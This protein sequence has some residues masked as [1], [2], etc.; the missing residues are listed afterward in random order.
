MI[1]HQEVMGI[2]KTILLPA[3]K[4]YALEAGASGN[5]RVQEVVR[6]YPDRYLCFANEVPSEPDAREVIEKYLKM[7][8]RGIGEQKFFIDCT[9]KEMS[10]ISDIA[11][12]HGVPILLHFQHERFNVNYDQFYRTLAR[13]PKV[14]YIGHAQT[15]WANIDLKHEQPILYPKWKVTAGGWTDRYLRDYPNFFADLSA[16]SGLNALQRDE[17]HARQFIVRHQDK[18]LYGSDCNDHIG[19]G[20]KCSGSQQIAMLKKLAPPEIR[21][22]LFWDNAARIIR[23]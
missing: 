8:A 6:K 20:L 2:A 12:H 7:G 23:L 21:K 13:Y 14:A 3:G 11:Q 22:K 15:T 5:D 17:E 19:A 9:G 4:M 16:G 1:T 18:L 10:L